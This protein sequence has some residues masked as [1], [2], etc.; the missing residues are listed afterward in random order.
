MIVRP[1]QIA[2]AGEGAYS[3]FRQRLLAHVA[4]F[5]PV[6]YHVAGRQQLLKLIDL[7]QGRAEAR[8]MRSERDI[9]LWVSLMLYLGSD[10]DTDPQFPAIQE[11]LAGNAPPPE[12]L[13]RAYDIATAFLNAAAGPDGQNAAAAAPRFQR[14]AYELDR[15]VQR[16][17]RDA[18]SWIY[19]QRFAA[20]SAEQVE[21]IGRLGQRLALDYSFERQRGSLLCSILAFLLGHGFVSDP[22]FPWAE[23]TL[24]KLTAGDPL[25]RTLQFRD[26]AAAGVGRWFQKPEATAQAS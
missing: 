2:S 1:L 20:L 11:A 25:R 17:L 23:Q 9:Y 10:F 4:E 18:L 12:R 19:P 21:A 24:S 6:H 22:Q 7:G 3:A 13:D 14:A 15:L 8:N 5:F 16:P 26:A